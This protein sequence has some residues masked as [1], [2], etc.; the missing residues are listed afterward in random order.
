V[1]PVATLKDALTLL[2]DDAQRQTVDC[3][4]LD[5]I[6]G[7]DEVFPAA[8]LCQQHAIPFVFHSA[9]ARRGDILA[10]FPSAAFCPKPSSPEDVVAGLQSVLAKKA[11]MV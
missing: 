1:G 10:D 11:T 4:I 2:G 5:I 3:A 6:L 7:K 8:H 9:H